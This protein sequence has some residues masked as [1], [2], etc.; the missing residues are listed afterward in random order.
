MYDAGMVALAIQV[1]KLRFPNRFFDYIDFNGPRMP[2]M[3]SCCWQWVGSV[4]K[5]GYGKYHHRKRA[6]ELNVL[7]AHRCAWVFW[8]RSPIPAKLDVHHRCHN[9]LCVN[10]GH[11]VAL[12]RRQHSLHHR[13]P[14]PSRCKYGHPLSGRNLYIRPDGKGAQCR[15]CQSIRSH[16]ENATAQF[17]LQRY[18]ASSALLT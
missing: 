14:R 5:Q 16:P 11:L 6:I 8:K 13:R 1:A 12:T 15:A 7:G 9:P 17:W 10:P 2:E 4:S 18:P 3:Q